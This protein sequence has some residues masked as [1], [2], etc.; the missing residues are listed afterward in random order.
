MVTPVATAE[1]A[2]AVSIHYLVY[3]SQADPKLTAEDL[4][5]ILKTSRAYNAAHGITGILLFVE[6]EGRERG[7]FMQLLE[8]DA[9]EVEKLRRRIFADPRHHTKIVLERGEKPQRDFA[10]WSMAY[11]AMEHSELKAHPAFADLGEE[12]FEARCA[13]DGMSQALRHLCDFWAD[14]A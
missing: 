4:E 13:R 3:V 11:K 1:G 10:G 2:Q 12:S 14:A 6:G 5:E 8:G 9:E 7:R